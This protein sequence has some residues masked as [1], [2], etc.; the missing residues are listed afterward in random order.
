VH[1][2]ELVDEAAAA[3]VDLYLCGHTH[4]GQICLPWIGPI[5]VNANCPRRYARGLWRHRHMQGYTSPGVGTSGVPVRF[6]C[7]PEIGVIELRCS[8]HRNCPSPVQT[9]PAWSWREAAGQ[10][11]PAQAHGRRPQRRRANGR[12]GRPGGGGRGALGRA[13]HAVSSVC[14]GKWAPLERAVGAR[15][16]HS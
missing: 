10:L 2:P 3:G 7:P 1:T 11:V 13:I 6:F 8:R 4:G 9:D 16:M 15:P 14:A 12:S 5:I